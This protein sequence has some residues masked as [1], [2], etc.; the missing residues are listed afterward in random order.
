MAR[1]IPLLRDDDE[2]FFLRA[3][4]GLLG[5]SGRFAFGVLSVGE[6]AIALESIGADDRIPIRVNFAGQFG[7]RV[8]F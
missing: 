6:A 4:L 1:D 2:A 8:E 5:R 3:N 7:Y